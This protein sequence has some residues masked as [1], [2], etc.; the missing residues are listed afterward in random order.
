MVA[1]S[2]ANFGFAILISLI[3]AALALTVG[4]L[5]TK[6][7]SLTIG[8]LFL[9]PLAAVTRL[10]KPLLLIAWIFSLT[11]FRVVYPIDSLAGFQGFYVTAADGVFLLLLAFW[12]Y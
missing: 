3:A 9:L 4:D 12:F 6:A 1:G 5:S 7:L 11:Y 8:V 2:L 10:T